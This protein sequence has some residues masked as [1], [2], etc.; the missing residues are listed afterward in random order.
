[1]STVHTKNYSIADIWSEEDVEMQFQ[2]LNPL[3][4]Q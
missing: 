2:T 3:R 1:V 4:T